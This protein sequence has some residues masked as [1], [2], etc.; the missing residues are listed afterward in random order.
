MLACLLVLPFDT[1]YGQCLHYFTRFG[2]EAST[3]M[4]LKSIFS[5]ICT[6][7]ATVSHWMSN[8]NPCEAGHLAWRDTIH[9]RTSYTIDLRLESQIN[10][11]IGCFSHCSFQGVGSS[12][13]APG[14]I[15]LSTF[16]FSPSP[17]TATVHPCQKSHFGFC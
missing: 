4:L 16:S 2:I 12:Y 13:I 3:A 6:C 1:K 14:L 5:T 15:V 11:V 10:D 7:L 17:T 9:I 8:V